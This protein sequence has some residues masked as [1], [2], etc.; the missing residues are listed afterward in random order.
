MPLNQSV[1]NAETN[2]LLPVAVKTLQGRGQLDFDLYICPAKGHRAI[3][4]REK[5]VPLE[6]ADL[7]RL[8]DQSVTTLYTR[9]SE[10]ERY[11]DHIRSRVLA[12]ESIPASERYG[13]LTEATR[14]V[15]TDSLEKG[16]VNGVLKVSGDF[17]R[18][19][20]SVVC[21]REHVLTELLAVMT[22]DYS[23][24]TH[25]T[26]VCTCCLLLAEAYGITDRGQL[27]AIAQGAL[28]HDLG[29]CYIPASILNKPASL[30]TEE[31]E[32]I[33]QHPQRGFEELCMRPELS[34]GQLMMVYQHHERVDGRGY[35]VGTPG[36]EIHLWGR[37]CAV[38]DVYDAL[39]RD[40]PY[41][42]G[43]DTREVLEYM[44]RESGRSFDEEI[45]QCWITTLERCPK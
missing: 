25:L 19:M 39:T 30:T 27:M 1:K 6:P 5:R 22:H 33:R 43:M 20:V 38:V 31:R 11:C 37:L 9:S 10:A 42:K 4:Y 28:L 2:G 41:R 40:R 36:D 23:T 18:D 44:K 24:F 12:D 45:C 16:D 26:N 3:M 29:K 21:N 8:L 15:L 17:G 34:W 7:Q 35:P 13:M 32:I 14:A